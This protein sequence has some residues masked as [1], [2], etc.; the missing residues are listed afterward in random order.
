MSKIKILCIDIEGGHG[1]SSRSLFYAL[2]E[3]SKIKNIQI[4]VIC[5]IDSWMKKEYKRLGIRCLTEKTIPRFTPLKKY[6]RNILQLLYFI[7]LYWLNP[8]TSEKIINSKDVDLVH[9]NYIYLSFLAYWLK[10]KSEKLAVQC[11]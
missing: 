6:S 10:K 1:G 5:R 3:I 7:F 9:Y 11:M 2:E 8:I 4:T